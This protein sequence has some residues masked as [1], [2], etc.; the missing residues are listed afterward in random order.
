MPPIGPK[1][2]I[3]HVSNVYLPQT[4]AKIPN[5][6]PQKKRPKQI[7]SMLFFMQT[8]I[9]TIRTIFVTSISLSL[10]NFIKEPLKY[11]PMP[12]P[13]TSDPVMIASK[14]FWSS[15]S[16]S[17]IAEKDMAT[18]AQDDTPKPICI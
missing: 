12:A 6:K 11:A 8:K 4:T 5:A 15:L 3:G 1:Y 14:F 10:P 16:Q 2:S 18:L 13:A 7:K 17:Y 9:D